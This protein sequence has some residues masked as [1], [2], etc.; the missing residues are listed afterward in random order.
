MKPKAK[1]LLLFVVFVAVV[2]LLESNLNA[3]AR[4][5]ADTKISS[6]LSTNAASGYLS[7]RQWFSKHRH[8]EYVL[9]TASSKARQPEK[10]YQTLMRNGGEA[11]LMLRKI[12]LDDVK[13]NKPWRVQ[14]GYEGLV[15]L[16]RMPWDSDLSNL[17]DRLAALLFEEVR[18]ASID[19]S[20]SLNGE[21]SDELFDIRE[22]ISM[23]AA[24]KRG[25]PALLDG[26]TRTKIQDGQWRL[27]LATFRISLAAC[28]QRAIDFS[29]PAKEAFGRGFGALWL[30]R[31][32]YAGWDMA[33]VETVKF[34]A[35]EDCKKFSRRYASMIDIVS[36][37]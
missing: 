34:G 23:Y 10:N 17:S 15:L 8:A 3:I 14:A 4:K 35:S 27:D 18:A 22:V 24:R 20:A 31:E 7:V 5:Y 28:T 19:E 1:V 9:A 36:A 2:L 13:E 25:Q 32:S 21:H 33:L 11:L 12:A 37:K 6:S 29:E 30:K 26:M 16:V